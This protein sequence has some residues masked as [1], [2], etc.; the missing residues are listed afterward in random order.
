MLP[1]TQFPLQTPWDA[2]AAVMV[3]NASSSSLLQHAASSCSSVDSLLLASTPAVAG[4]AGSSYSGM[5]G[6]LAASLT[7]SATNNHSNN[8]IASSSTY[9]APYM[10][11]SCG[12]AFSSPA[13]WMGSSNRLAS[14][15]SLSVSHLDRTISS[16]ITL[17]PMEMLP[18]SPGEGGGLLAG[19]V[20]SGGSVMYKVRVRARARVQQHCPLGRRAGCCIQPCRKEPQGHSRRKS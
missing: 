10:P 1:P 4:A 7:A 17:G 3:Q 8:N 13:P 16:P 14:L 12:A 5:G 6:F 2:A 18:S 20:A 11:G 9:G 19:G 15:D